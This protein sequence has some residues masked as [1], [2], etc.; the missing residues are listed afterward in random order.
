[1]SVNTECRKR[2]T[3]SANYRVRFLL[4]G[5]LLSGLV[6][7]SDLFDM[8]DN[9]DK[10]YPLEDYRK[11]KFRQGD[12]LVYTDQ[13]GA[14]FRLVIKEIKYD[15]RWTSRKSTNG[16]YNIIDRQSVY[17]DSA[18]II[19]PTIPVPGRGIYTVQPDGHVVWERGLYWIVGG[20]INFLD[21]LTL[22]A[23]V[24]QSVYKIPEETGPPADITELYYSHAYGIVGFQR[25][26]G[27]L[28]NLHIPK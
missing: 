9:R 22:N 17:Y 1:M 15:Q 28:F 3:A 20:N 2:K 4:C 8:F 27:Q 10:H 12:T 26:N 5:L 13:H 18:D 19:P 24:Y 16:P 23:T 11:I 21:Q 25:S 6:A 14:K 7:C